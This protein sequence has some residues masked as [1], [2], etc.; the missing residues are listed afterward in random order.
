MA[1]VDAGP[2]P[3]LAP[4]PRRAYLISLLL[5]AI[6]L[7][8]AI[9]DL[10]PTYWVAGISGVLLLMATY[11]WFTQWHVMVGGI[12]LI[13][14]WVPIGRYGLPITLPFQL[15]PYR[16]MVGV[17]AIAWVTTM[18]A[19][20]KKLPLRPSG[21][22]GP[23]LFLWIVIAAG[24]A[25]NIG[26]IQARGVMMDVLFK[27]SFLASYIVVMLLIGN[28]IRTRQDIDRAIKIL[29]FGGAVVGFFTLVEN[30]TGFNVFN[31]LQQV[32]P[33]FRFDP[34]QVPTY[35][36]QRGSGNRVMA[37]AQH[38]IAL[39][40]ALATLL[41]LGLY[42]G[43][44]TKSYFWWGCVGMIA[45]GVL[46][47][48]ARTAIL[49]LIVEAITLACL[50]PA[51]VKR[52]WWAILPFV[53]VVNIAV[54]ST[55]GTIKASFF[56]EGGLVAQQNTNPGGDASNR[57]SDIGPSLHEA[58]A[59]PFFGQGWGTRVPA[60]LDPAKT[61]RYLDDQWL[62]LVLEAGYF[63]FI[64]FIWFFGRNVRLLGG[65]ALRDQSSHGWLLAGLAASIFGFA[66]GMATYDA[67]GFPQATLLMYIMCGLGIAARRL[68][69]LDDNPGG[70]KPKAEKA[71]P[72]LELLATR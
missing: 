16:A 50:K 4:V 33:I 72:Q 55:L 17:V 6:M 69:A 12:F 42:L 5:A 30:K 67:F 39:G 29:M 19:E 41:P 27:I 45:L 1:A 25:S 31:H 20:P 47:T 46:T 40:T 64:A 54:P 22:R 35:L 63:G 7:A 48:V 57:V 15:E 26:T 71:A 14:L 36:E 2:S 62:G 9:L 44:R 52:L 58:K 49:M 51:T 10:R 24:V 38:P 53:L 28:V 32:I 65:A 60:K 8:A 21:L 18:L 34:S 37:S 70:A 11:R 56:P 43:F 68:P 3:A 23:L 61:R 66:I 13:V 59:T